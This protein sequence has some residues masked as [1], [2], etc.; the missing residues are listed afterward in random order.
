[1]L[2]EKYAPKNSKEMIGNK[3]AMAEFAGFLKQWKKGQ[4]AL[5]AGETGTGK[6]ITARLIAQ[7]LGY[8]VVE[9]GADEERKQKN[10][11]SF[12]SAAKQS[13]LVKKK[14]LF[15]IDDLDQMESG[16]AITELISQSE[17]PV[18]LITT[19][20]Y[21]RKLYALRQRCKIIKFS[22]VRSDSIAKFLQQV[23]EKEEIE[24]EARDLEQIAKMSSGDVRAALIDMET[25]GAGKADTKEIG[26]R[27]QNHDIFNTLKIIFKTTSMENALIALNSAG[28]KE[29]LH[30]WVAENI[31]EEYD[32]AEDVARAYD[33]ISKADIFYSRIIRRQSWG[34]QRY[35][36]E[37]STAGVALAKRSQYSKFVKYSRPAFRQR[38][39]S[40]ALQKI[41]KKLHV[42]ARKAAAYKQ[43]IKSMAKNE[44]MLDELG[45]T[46]EELREI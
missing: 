25:L 14:K 32:N 21:D 7:E 36:M 42:S 33:A 8:E 13:G 9:I 35:F 1:M 46:K 38:K 15:V 4:A 27:E 26:Y 12:V 44:K 2:L 37:L 29:E 40:E 5:I 20:L 41:S 31:S 3:L 10:M 28:D 39:N 23:C 24:C 45:V 19:G 16:K 43:L 11:E 30:R 22:R 17:H 6:S 18:I 34:L